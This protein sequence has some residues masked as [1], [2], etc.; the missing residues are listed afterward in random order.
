M[1]TLKAQIS[2]VFRRAEDI[3]AWRRIGAFGFLLIF[4][5]YYGWSWNT[6]DLLR[7]DIRA[8]F[9]LTLTEAALMYT[10]QSA[11]ALVGAVVIGQLADRLGRRNA[12]FGIMVG[13]SLS[14][15]AGAFVTDLTQLLTQRFILGV[16]LGGVFPVAVA[17]YTSL[18]DKRHC[19][20]LAGFYNG[21]FNGSIVALGFIVSTFEIGDWR[22][23]LWL[24]AIPPL[25][26][27]PLTFL[28][29]PDDRKTLPYGF[30]STEKASGKLP[31]AELFAPGLRRKTL[32][33]C[34]MVGLNFFAYQAF[35]GWQTTYLQDSLGL[36]SAVAKGLLAWQFTAT[37]IGGF[38]WGYIADRY[39][40]RVNAFGF[41]GATLLIGLYL[42]VGET[43]AQLRIIGFLLGLLIPASVIWGPW[44]AEM[45]P[46]HLRSTA[47]SIFN[48]GRIISLFSPP[49]TAAVAEGFG[50]GAAMALG[51]I[52]WFLAALVWRFLPE[53]LSRS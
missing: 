52:S 21:T 31:A 34:L 42:T 43:V 35:A 7:P 29:V 13:Y 27:S 14:L 12:M 18:F 33:I 44:I 17:I 11:G 22:Y 28:M 48:W 36:S 53:T 4:D 8:A 5:F 2:P 1:E 16:F 50:L 39:G 10:A 38:L 47:A 30:A 24:G 9:G 41:I 6:V 45:F 51:G 32:L 26:L 19:G 40:R 3:P 46:P 20:R 49:I 15:L 23:L 25:L 37:I